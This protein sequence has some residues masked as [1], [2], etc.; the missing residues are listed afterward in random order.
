MKAGK[1]TDDETNGT[2]DEEIANF[3]SCFAILASPSRNNRRNSS[4]QKN[5]SK[6]YCLS[7]PS[8]GISSE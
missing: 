4:S 5:R 1:T 6:F 7:F 3:M 2:A 8:S